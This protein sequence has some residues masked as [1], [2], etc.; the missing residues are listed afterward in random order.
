MPHV[1]PTFEREQRAGLRVGRAL[2]VAHAVADPRDVERAEV[3]APEGA[4]G[5][6]LHRHRER[7]IDAA[8]GRIADETCVVKLRAPEMTVGIDAGAVGEGR[9]FDRGEGARASARAAHRVVVE[10]IDAVLQRIGE[11]HRAAVRAEGQAVGNGN[12]AGDHF[13]QALRI[14]AEQAAFGRAGDVLHRAHPEAPLAVATAVVEAVVWR[15]ARLHDGLEGFVGDIEQRQPRTQRDEH[16]AIA[17]GQR[18]RA[19]QLGHRPGLQRLPRRCPAA[20]R[21][22]ADIDPPQTLQALVPQRAFA[23]QVGLH[24]DARRPGLRKRRG[25][26]DRRHGGHRRQRSAWLPSTKRQHTIA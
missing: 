21:R 25:G 11:V 17:L 2:G 22:R 4:A 9:T 1:G 13:T 15:Q 3:L 19:D 8:I 6:A 23:E 14:E 7:A 12:A 20:Q 26:G 18:D 24:A 5:G 10:G 16:H